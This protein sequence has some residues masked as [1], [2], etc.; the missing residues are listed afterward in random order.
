MQSFVWG[1][2]IVMGRLPGIN[3]LAG[4][5]ILLYGNRQ[6]GVRNRRVATMSVARNKKNLAKLK[7]AFVEFSGWKT[8][9]IS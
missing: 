3:M 9:G 5:L 8:Q 6:L 4:L 1:N 2:N 7:D